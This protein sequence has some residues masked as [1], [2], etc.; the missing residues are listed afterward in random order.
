MA[1]LATIRRILSLF[2]RYENRRKLAI[3]GP[4]WP[5]LWCLRIIQKSR[6]KPH[7]H[8]VYSWLRGLD[9]NQRPQGYE[10]CELPGCSTPRSGL[11]NSAG[12]LRER[13]SFYPL[14]RAAFSRPPWAAIIEQSERSPL[15]ILL[16]H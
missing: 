9:L 11:R 3:H 14:P 12:A 2:Y 10:P 7:C 6:E 8:C 15:S 13:K 4:C 1:F 16:I 5:V